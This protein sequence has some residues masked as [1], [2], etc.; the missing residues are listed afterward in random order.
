ME[1]IAFPDQADLIGKIQQS[2]RSGNKRIAAFSSVGSGK[3]E[4]IILLAKSS[5]AKGNRCAF[6]D[7]RVQRTTQF[8]Q[9]LEKY[10]FLD[11]GVMQGEN[12]RNLSAPLLV[13][14]I[15][16]VRNRG[17]LP[18][19]IK[20]L[21]VDEAHY[22]ANPKVYESL[23]KNRFVIGVTGSPW[24][25]LG[26]HV[27]SLDGPL[28][29][30]LICHKS[31]QELF[32]TGR[33]L[34]PAVISLETVDMD[35]VK[36]VIRNGEKGFDEEEGGKRFRGLTGDVVGN[37]LH[38]CPGEQALVFSFDI[39]SSQLLRDAFTQAGIK[40]E[41]ID[42]RETDREP[43]YDAFRNRDFQVLCNVELLGCGFD[44][45]SCSV[46][47]LNKKYKSKNQLMQAMGRCMRVDPS[48]ASKKATVIDHGKSLRDLGLPWYWDIEL[49]DGKPKASQSKQEQE[50]KTPP[51]PFECPR[52]KRLRQIKSIPC[53]SCGH[54]I[55]RNE[56]EFRPEGE[57]VILNGKKKLKKME[58]LSSHPKQEIYA[59][60]LF[61]A[62]A[63]NF[64]E[65]WAVHKFHDIYHENPPRGTIPE[66]PIPELQ[67]WIRAQNIKWIKGKGKH[68]GKR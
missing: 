17:G 49:L 36:E 6:I 20:I 26:R 64:K 55:M 35:G 58:E 51:K 57:I 39:E 28:Y 47:I 19:D 41:H 10:D 32:N 52:C 34:E 48:N 5:I 25:K 22:S 62:K 65:G 12:S 56:E 37:Y 4:I 16:T 30:D 60:L 38:L 21:F 46:V 42:Y 11:F 9:R 45:P 59:G 1:L 18:D 23:F 67:M 66:P 2:A 53:P 13:C 50:K 31:M 27:A 63:R 29:Q 24:A 61:H 14:S 3:S 33:L 15:D 54:R 40:A 44:A 7:N 68:Y 43:I 8:C